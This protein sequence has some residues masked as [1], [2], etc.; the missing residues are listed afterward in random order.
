[1]LQLDVN[2]GCLSQR[3]FIFQSGY[4][5]F[6]YKNTAVS[7]QRCNNIQ[8]ICRQAGLGT[9]MKQTTALSKSLTFN[10]SMTLPK[11]KSLKNIVLIFI[12][13][14]QAESSWLFSLYKKKK[15]NALCLIVS[16]LDMYSLLLNIL[17]PR[18]KKLYIF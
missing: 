4:S 9:S 13:I 6:S 18:H 14:P 3:S 17:S 12:K 7:S 15:I 11:K 2:A 1:M 8:K 5:A 16:I 10:K